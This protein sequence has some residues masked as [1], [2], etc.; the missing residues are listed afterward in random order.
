ML[1]KSQ[2]TDMDVEPYQAEIDR[3]EEHALILQKVHI[4]ICI[5]F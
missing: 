3:L 1:L 4:R 2:E 5:H